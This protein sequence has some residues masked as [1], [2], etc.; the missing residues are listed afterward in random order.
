LDYERCE[1]YDT[2]ILAIT[3]LSY[4]KFARII[5]RGYLYSIYMN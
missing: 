4:G 1:L 3:P 2:L 5:H